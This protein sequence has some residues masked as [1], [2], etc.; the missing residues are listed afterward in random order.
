MEAFSKIDPWV[1][2]PQCQVGKTS[3]EDD[4]IRTTTEKI[5]VKEK[6]PKSFADLNLDQALLKS[7]ASEGYKEPTQIQQLAIPEVLKRNDLIATA[8]TGSGKTAAFALPI[9]Q[10]LGVRGVNAK[11]KPRALVLTPT[12][13]LASQV[14]ESFATYGKHTSMRRIVIYG[15]V[16]QHSQVKQ[17]LRGGDVL[18]ATPGRLLDLINQGFVKLDQLEFF[19]LDEADRMLDMGFIG[20]IEKIISYMPNSVQALLFSATMP[21]EIEK[22]ADKL[23]KNPVKIG[24][25]NKS[26]PVDTVTSSVYF[27]EKSYKLALLKELLSS[28]EM[29]KVLVFSRTKRGADRLAQRLQQ[30]RFRVDAIHGNKSQAF[31]EKALAKFKSGRVNILVATDI[32][33]R[34]ID[35]DDISHVIN[36]D[37]P[38]EAETYIHRIGRTARAGKAGISL[39]F[40]E[41][42]ERYMLQR[43]EKLIG[44]KIPRVTGH[45]FESNIPLTVMHSENKR[46]GSRRRR[47]R[48]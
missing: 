42:K 19:V 2:A 40:C 39:S 41:V 17:L 38:D 18:V 21:R 7:V 35:V 44:S 30:A 6:F 11:K 12:R 37:L 26:S 29:Q 28:P 32:A 48:N 10:L 20:D 31:R 22:L 47:Y 15:G 13:E 9:I 16:R 5:Q 1:K 3:E 43:I 23:M 14:G 25:N 4:N 46:R 33:A 8:Q 24:L 45:R 36:F 27:V 34:G